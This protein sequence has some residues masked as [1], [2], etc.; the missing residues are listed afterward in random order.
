M[1]GKGEFSSSAVTVDDVHRVDKER[2]DVAPLSLLIECVKIWRSPSSAV[3]WL[4]YR[5]SDSRRPDHNVSL[6]HT[7]D[8]LP[9]SS[10]TF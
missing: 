8:A 3:V 2:S 9:S 7:G 10:G 4:D 1:A 6:F 5:E